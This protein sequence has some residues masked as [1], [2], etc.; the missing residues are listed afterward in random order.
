MKY[1]I[2]VC[3]AIIEDKNKFLIAK[4]PLDKHNGGRWEFPGGKVEFGEDPRKALEREIFE[5]LGVL[6][7]A[8]GLLEYSSHVYSGEKHVILLGIHC[9]FIKGKVKKK[10]IADFKWVSLDEMNKYD[11]TEADLPFIV[12]LKEK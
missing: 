6:V 4:R 9:S 11:I 8:E 1:P 10:E 3:A 5:E 7:K 2:L 12:K